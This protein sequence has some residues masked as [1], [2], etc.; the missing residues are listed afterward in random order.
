MSD[1]LSPR[2]L[3]I[4]ATAAVL[5]IGNTGRF[6]AVR[7]MEKTSNLVPMDVALKR[8]K[9]VKKF[10]GISLGEGIRPLIKHYADTTVNR[11]GLWLA[12]LAYLSRPDAMKFVEYKLFYPDTWAWIKACAM[13]WSEQFY[14]EEVI[15]A[16]VCYPSCELDAKSYFATWEWR[17]DFL[18]KISPSCSRLSYNLNISCFRSSPYSP[19]VCPTS[20]SK[21]LEGVVEVG[22]LLFGL[23]LR[24]TCAKGSI[25]SREYIIITPKGLISQLIYSF[26][27]NNHHCGGL[28]MKVT[29]DPYE[30]TLEVEDIQIEGDDWV[31]VDAPVETFSNNSIGSFFLIKKFQ[32]KNDRVLEDYI[33]NSKLLEGIIER[34]MGAE[35]LLEEEWSNFL[36]LCGEKSQNPQYGD[37]REREEMNP[38]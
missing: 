32:K 37:Q 7:N 38:F 28:V 26:V 6:P 12:W 17:R 9:E 5:E 36:R 33:K 14:P 30:R 13:D 24:L 35:V 3:A 21:K 31:D 8:S 15:V 16:A 11:H 27:P 25:F 22:D 4:T 1:E 19:C 2:E 29:L 23:P 18:Q 10:L 20:V 34:V